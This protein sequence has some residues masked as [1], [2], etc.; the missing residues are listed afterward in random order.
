MDVSAQTPVSSSSDDMVVK[1]QKQLDNLKKNKAAEESQNIKQFQKAPVLTSDDIS[2]EDILNAFRT[3]RQSEDA[4]LT[5]Q[6]NVAQSI[7]NPADDLGLDSLDS[8]G[9]AVPD[10]T[11]QNLTSVGGSG[12]SG[13]QYSPP[14]ADDS[15][16]PTPLPIQSTSQA[17]G[18]VRKE[19]ISQSNTEETVRYKEIGAELTHD[20]ELEKWIEEV[21]DPAKITLPKPVHDEYGQ[22]L[23]QAS[24]IPKPKIILPI[25]EPEMEK[26]LHH[27]VADSFR[28]LYEWAKRIILLQPGR[29]YY[30]KKQL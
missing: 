13:G 21:P 1:L 7:I 24:Q 6:K 26:A 5:N 15:V 3:T 29:V 30:N 9:T 18:S 20:K 16:P 2:A 28:W 8:G 10:F 22:I 12:P 23:V 11:P 19:S 25:T 27:K 14:T 4:N 17:T